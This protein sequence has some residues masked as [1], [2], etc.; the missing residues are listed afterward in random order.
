MHIGF[1]LWFICGFKMAKST[2]YDLVYGVKSNWGK[3]TGFTFTLLRL[4][5][6]FKETPGIHLTL[7]NF[8][9]HIRLEKPYE[10]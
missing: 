2:K 4:I 6:V 1:V 7:F 3:G 10:N 8:L 5:L 9:F